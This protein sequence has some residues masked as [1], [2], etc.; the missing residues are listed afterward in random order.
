M[1]PL[2]TDFISDQISNFPLNVVSHR[3]GEVF[4]VKPSINLS[5]EENWKEPLTY[6]HDLEITRPWYY[7][8]YL[9]DKEIKVEFA[10]GAKAG[11]YRFSFPK[12]SQ[13]A[14]LLGNYN[15]GNASYKMIS[16]RIVT[17]LETYHGNI[18]VYLYG[19]F[20]IPGNLQ[21]ISNGKLESKNEVAGETV[22]AAVVFDKSASPIVEFRYALSYIS[23]DQ[24]LKNFNKEIKN[25]SFNTI[26]AKA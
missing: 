16:D 25:I 3:L 4:S 2:R 14:I 17:G 8:T 20:T 7:S 11:I 10:P 1:Y 22:K 15:R 12:S 21:V 26:S 19:E 18:K 9:V 5:G 24:A 13:K 6:D 23:S